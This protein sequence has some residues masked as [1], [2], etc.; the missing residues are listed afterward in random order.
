MKKKNGDRDVAERQLFHG[1]GS[2]IVDA[3]CRQGF[4]FRLSG[5][6]VGKAGLLIGLYCFFRHGTPRYEPGLLLK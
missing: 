2:D 5:S 6:N 3:I 1:T 4:D